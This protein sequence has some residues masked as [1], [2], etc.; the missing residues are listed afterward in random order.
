MG[1]VWIDKLVYEGVQF[2]SDSVASS[3]LMVFFT[4]VE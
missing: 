3:L 4:L 2:Y 1:G